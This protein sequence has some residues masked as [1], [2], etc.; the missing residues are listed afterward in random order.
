MS[1]AHGGVQDDYKTQNHA[2]VW[3]L[4]R[5]VRGLPASIMPAGQIAILCRHAKVIHCSVDRVIDASVSLR[6]NISLSTLSFAALLA[7]NVF[8][9]SPSCNFGLDGMGYGEVEG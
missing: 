3:C 8:P 2:L 4:L 7:L 9:F 5:E 6:T 1:T